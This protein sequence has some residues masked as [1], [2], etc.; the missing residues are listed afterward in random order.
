MGLNITGAGFQV[1]A[2]D[3]VVYRSCP[4]THPNHVSKW[5]EDILVMTLSR[6]QIAPIQSTVRS[7]VRGHQVVWYGHMIHV[8]ETETHRVAIRTEAAGYIVQ[9]GEEQ[10]LC[11][12]WCQDLNTVLL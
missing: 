11:L 1:V 9:M 2:G 10:I 8:A 5:V 7:S 12:I 6:Y 3:T 4:V